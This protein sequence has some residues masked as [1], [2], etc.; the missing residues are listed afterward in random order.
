MSG[1]RR[2]HRGKVAAVIAAALCLVA[3]L[4]LSAPTAAGDSPLPSDGGSG[5]PG[6]PLTLTAGSIG[7]STGLVDADLPNGANGPVTLSIGLCIPQLKI[8][9]VG[10]L[11]QFSLLGNF[12]D[13]AGNPLYSGSAPRGSQLD[14][15]RPGVPPDL[16][17]RPR[18]QHGDAAA[19]RRVPRAHHVR[20]APQPER[21]VPVV[22]AGAGMQ[23]GGGSTLADWH[24][25]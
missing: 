3:S 9:C 13:D 5:L 16:G 10:V 12:K 4:L 19:D 20:V 14:L 23:R 21:H 15:Q 25:Q 7:L 22:R 6:V 24:H 17:I 8:T 18:H 2:R 1:P 11:S